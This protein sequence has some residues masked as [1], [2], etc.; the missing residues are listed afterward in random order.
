[1]GSSGSIKL[2]ADHQE[3]QD[4]LRQTLRAAFPDAA[5]QSRNP[6]ADAIAKA[7]MPYMDAV[8]EECLR[9]GLPTPMIAREAMMNTDILGHKVPKGTTI[10]ISSSGPG[11]L[12]LPLKISESVRSETSQTKHWGEKWD[13]DDM[14]LFKP[15]RWLKTG[16]DGEVVYDSQAGPFL[17]FGL[18]P[19]G[20]F[21]KRL[22]YLEMRIVM[23]LL[24]W[25]FH[26]RKLSDDLSKYDG[27]EAV[28]VMPKTC[29][30]GIEKV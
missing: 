8:I 21:G 22:A 14:H 9:V 10:L 4:K 19:R 24:F 13:G 12:S 20:C 2:L 18:G 7:N 25:N 6:T 30:V 5:S 29:Y 1:M 11:Y 17:A 26:F 16:D 3:A 15:E 23:T 27:V 28:T